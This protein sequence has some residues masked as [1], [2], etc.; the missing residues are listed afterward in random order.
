[1]SG[2]KVKLCYKDAGVQDGHR[3]ACKV[4]RRAQAVLQASP[5]PHTV[6]SLWVCMLLGHCSE[7]CADSRAAA[8]AWREALA[9]AGRKLPAPLNACLDEWRC[10]LQQRLSALRDSSGA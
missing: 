3:R 6:L 4:L 1:M 8:A 9:V 2:T 5:H 7:G 10:V